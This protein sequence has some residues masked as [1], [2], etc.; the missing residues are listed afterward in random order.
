VKNPGERI[1]L[2]V[3][4]VAAQRALTPGS[5]ETVSLGREVGRKRIAAITD[6]DQTTGNR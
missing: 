4:P 6:P 5:D 3:A 2:S 1:P